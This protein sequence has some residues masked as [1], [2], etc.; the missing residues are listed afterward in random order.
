MDLKK[1]EAWG[2][3]LRTTLRLDSHHAMERFMIMLALLL[4]M[5]VVVM[6]GAFTS[7][8]SK[9][10]EDLSN[11]SV[12]TPTFKTSQSEQEGQLQAVY[13]NTEKTRALLLMQFKDASKMSTD[14]EKYQ[15][16]VTSSNPKNLGSTS[17]PKTELKGSIITFGSTGYMGVM[18][19]SDK[20]FKED[21]LAVTMR[22]N[23]QLDYKGTDEETSSEEKVKALA[24]GDSFKE[25]DQWRMFVNPGAK[26]TTTLADLDATNPDSAAVF[27]D[28][29]LKAKE[30]EVRNTMDNHLEQMKVDLQRVEEYK[31]EMART[32]VDGVRIIPPKEPREIAGDA[33]TGSKA[34]GDVPSSLAL[35]TDWVDPHG[36][37]FNWRE[38]SIRTGY[39]DKIVP[40]GQSYSSFLQKK[41]GNSTQESGSSTTFNSEDLTWKLSDGTTLEA[42][43]NTGALK[44]L[45]SIRDNLSTAY[46]D[47]I[48]HKTEYQT[49]DY[50]SL[51][52]LELQLRSVSSSQSVNNDPKAVAIYGGA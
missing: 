24:S 31:S 3:K 14:A 13:T 12:Y 8:F 19:D 5:L 39:L 34:K 40:A 32:S 51:L 2:N 28:A 42:S 29:V 30:S 49:K 18:L 25:H 48:T 23:A 22:A 46:Q 15:A 6:T 35:K 36:F 37:N 16:F 17:K 50:N 9:N 47:Y 11:T 45:T 4:A 43:T 27:Y 26:G 7:A 10:S 1:M 41:M 52:D 33:V 44:P 38:G 20:P 21:L